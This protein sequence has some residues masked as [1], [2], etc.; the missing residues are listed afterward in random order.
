MFDSATP[1]AVQTVTRQRRN[2]LAQGT[3][4][5]V[6]AAVTSSP[7]VVDDLLVAQSKT[8]SGRGSFSGAASILSD[9]KESF[10]RVVSSSG[11]GSGGGGGAGGGAAEMMA[12]IRELKSM[13]SALQSQVRYCGP[14]IMNRCMLTTPARPTGLVLWFLRFLFPHRHLHMNASHVA[15]DPRWISP[16]SHVCCVFVDPAPRTVLFR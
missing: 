15:D 7:M 16:R 4:A 10:G 14:L 9:S 2:T 11:S 3:A 5:R 6:A 13:V 1:P 8:S 12:A